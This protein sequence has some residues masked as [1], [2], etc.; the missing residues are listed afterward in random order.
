MP[1]YSRI[2]LDPF[3]LLTGSNVPSNDSIL[4]FY[5]SMP[6]TFPDEEVRTVGKSNDKY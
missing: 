3:S 2:G 5:S 1:Q 6:S 4:F